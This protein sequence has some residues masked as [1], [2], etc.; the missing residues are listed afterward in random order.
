MSE[1]HVIYQDDNA[2]QYKLSEIERTFPF[3]EELNSRLKPFLGDLTSESLKNLAFHQDKIKEKYIKAVELDVSK[4]NLSTP[5]AK[6]NLLTG[7]IKDIGKILQHINDN[8]YEVKDAV[9]NVDFKDGHPYISEDT[10]EKIIESFRVYVATEI[11]WQAYQLHCEAIEAFNRF[12]KFSEENL[13]FKF[14]TFKAQAISQ[15]Y[16]KWDPVDEKFKP[17]LYYYDSLINKTN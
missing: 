9:G 6:A 3:L 5:T 17:E 1:K 10:K 12:L 7:G 4:L 14:T 16:A 15:I 11:G 2:I 8:I 13:H